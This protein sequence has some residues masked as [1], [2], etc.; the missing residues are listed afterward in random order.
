VAFDNDQW[1][2]LVCISGL[3]ALI[4]LMYP[5]ILVERIV[6]PTEVH[7]STDEETPVL[8]LLPNL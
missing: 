6:R 7:Q 5:V 3:L 2:L 4:P 1:Y 8:N